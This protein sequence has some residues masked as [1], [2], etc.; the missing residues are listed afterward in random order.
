MSDIAPLHGTTSLYHYLPCGNVLVQK[1]NYRHIVIHESTFNHLYYELDGSRAA[2]KEDCIEYCIYY[3]EKHIDDYPKWFRDAMSDGWI[4]EVYRG[5][6]IV[7]GSHIYFEEGGE[8]LMSPG[9]IIMKNFMGD[10]KYMESD[11][12]ARY[13]DTTGGN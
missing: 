9:S 10:L 2:L 7:P 3:P 13:Y 4:E 8:I 12:F 5:H 11:H 1:A 6:Q